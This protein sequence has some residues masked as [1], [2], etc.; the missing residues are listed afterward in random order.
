[1]TT[2][3]ER[4]PSTTA[5]ALIRVLVAANAAIVCDALVSRL[6]AEP[7]LVPIAAP[8]SRAAV[9]RYAR[10]VGQDV[11]VLDIVEGNREDEELVRA[12][13]DGP[14]N[15]AVVAL[16]PYG[17]PALA[18]RIVVAGA[19]GVVLKT[20]SANELVDAIRWT[21]DSASWISPPLL[22]E[23]IDELHRASSPIGGK[24]LSLL[25]HR[26]LEVIQLMVD[27][28]G[29]R[30]ISDEL[31][32]SVDTVRT[33]MRTIMEKLEVHAATAAV[34]IALEAGLRPRV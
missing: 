9:E 22:R 20:A 14:C 26:E 11:V 32:L 18:A 3:L 34:S 27:G 6:D 30:Q 13:R 5:S 2:A 16:V 1:M 4:G 31:C 7:D 15:P 21:A 23:V 12:L 8:G 19:T 24:A 28:L 33:H 25:T 10:A 29:R 17:E